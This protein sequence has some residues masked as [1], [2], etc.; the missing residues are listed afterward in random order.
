MQAIQ[1]KHLFSVEDWRKM[2]DAGIFAPDARLELIEGE[3]LNMPPIGSLH[4]SQLKRLTHWFRLKTAEDVII[5]V[6]D[7]L[8]L[9]DFSEPQ[10]DLM[11]LRPRED[12]YADEHPKPEDVLLLIEVADST[13]ARDREIKMPLYARYGVAEY[14]LL[15]LQDACIE[16]YSNPTAKGYSDRHM[17]YK[18]EE[19]SLKLLPDLRVAVADI[20]A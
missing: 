2:G 15:N 14:W 9:G 11:L 8:R 10:P 18:G 1:E 12:F 5:S 16:V 20:L 4:S 7:P 13:L 19:L 6:Q 17:A 3:V